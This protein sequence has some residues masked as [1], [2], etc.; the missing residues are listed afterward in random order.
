MALKLGELRTINRATDL[1]FKVFAKIGAI[2]SVDYRIKIY[3]WLGNVV[4]LSPS[5]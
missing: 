5:T 4:G 1:V 2:T 3:D